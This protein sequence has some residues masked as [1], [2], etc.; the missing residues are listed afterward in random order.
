MGRH[1]IGLLYTDAAASDSGT[2]CRNCAIFCGCDWWGYANYAI[3]WLALHM[4][5]LRWPQGMLIVAAARNLRQTFPGKPIHVYPKHL[6]PHSK[7]STFVRHVF[8]GPPG[9][10]RSSSIQYGKSFN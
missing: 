4:G 6:N 9:H 2:Y 1:D 5:I 8:C 10:L 7:A 3:C